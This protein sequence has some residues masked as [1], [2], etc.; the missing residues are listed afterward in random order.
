M[1]FIM[2]VLAVIRRLGVRIA[3]GIFAAGLLLVSIESAY[4]GDVVKTPIL[5]DFRNGSSLA[6]SFQIREHRIYY[7]DLDFIS[8]R[9]EDRAKTAAIVGDA[10][11]GCME[12]NACGIVTQIRIE[13]QDTSGTVQ[14]VPMKTLFGPHGH[15][16]FT[17]DGRYMRNLGTLPLRPGSYRLVATATDVD[18]RI[19]AQ[20]VDLAIRFDSRASILRD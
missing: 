15:Y 8:E 4:A 5:P 7:I 16:A 13:I 10:Y 17:L 12:E 20:P 14:P 11:T 2:K 3:P 18:S 1:L 6:V 19:H 9:P